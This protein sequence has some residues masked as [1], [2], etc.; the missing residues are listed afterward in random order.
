MDSETEKT[1]L[2]SSDH[3]LSMGL[4]EDVTRVIKAQ[5]PTA[6]ATVK[7]SSTSWKNKV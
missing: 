2:Q 4:D 6:N 7:M 1:Y 3:S 5:E